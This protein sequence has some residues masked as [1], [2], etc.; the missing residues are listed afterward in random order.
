MASR[1][2]CSVHVLDASPAMNYYLEQDG[3]LL[4]LR[5]ALDRVGA[6]RVVVHHG[7]PEISVKA[8]LAGVPQLLLPPGRFETR[9]M[10]ERL[11]ALGCGKTVG[12][13]HHPIQ[14]MEKALTQAGGDGEFQAIT[15]A[16]A[17]ELATSGPFP[18]KRA[19]RDAVGTA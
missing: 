1:Q 16:R 7:E 3:A 5:E 2:K 8:A 4:S 15:R 18:G 10:A 11:N 17:G 14:A 13:S 12:L 9:A 19:I 6:A